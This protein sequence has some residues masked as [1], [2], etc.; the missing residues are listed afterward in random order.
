MKPGEPVPADIQAFFCSFIFAL[1]SVIKHYAAHAQVHG[2]KMTEYSF[3]KGKN[4]ML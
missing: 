3:F 4:P 1:Y 2:F